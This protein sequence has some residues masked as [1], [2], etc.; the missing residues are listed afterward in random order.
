MAHPLVP[1]AKAA[2]LLRYRTMV[3]HAAEG[4]CVGQGGSIRFAN[5]T[6]LALLGVDAKRIGERPMIEYVH[7]QD[8]AFV[9]SQRDKRSR[10]EVVPPFE[11]RFQRDDGQVSWVEINGVVIDWD[12]APA[13][14]F[15][16]K[17][18]TERHA[19]DEQLK[20]ALAQREAI[21]ETT[22]VGVT[23]LLQRRHQ[24]LNRTFATMLGWDDPAQLLGQETRIHFPSEAEFEQ[25]GAEAYRQID[26]T[27]HHSSVVQL[28][29][30]DGRLIWV[31][32]EG[33]AMPGGASRGT[34]WT[35]VDVTQ[36]RAAE[37]E[38]QNA[39]QREREL[40]EL[41]TR[42]LSM[43]SHEFRTPLAAILSSAEL[44]GHYGDKIGPEEQKS[45]MADLVSAARRMQLMLEDMLTL[46]AAEA[47]RL[48]FAPQPTDLPALCREV[49]AE[50]RSAQASGHVL[51]LEIAPDCEALGAARLVD[52]RLVHHIV[53]NLV[54]NACKYSPAGSE[55]TLRLACGPAE[56]VLEVSDSGIGIPEA[57]LPHL[58]DSF[59]RGGN[60]GNR[61]GSGL[62]L[63]I[64]KRCV[65][66]HG[67]KI[68]VVS[69][70][71]AG[72]RFAVTL[73]A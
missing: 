7:P 61:P 26:L 10:G 32:V 45:I 47:G 13:N 16:L 27:G 70:L 53:G 25:L 15:F 17:D 54:T 28:Q 60:A 24:W 4:V 50:V 59:H 68:A 12:G 56:V 34:V 36:R 6:C 51:K 20:S 11:A 69:K 67:G 58:F 2:E 5:A 65:E 30:K 9:T 66:L 8:R 35:Y 23:F 14:L 63:A 62:G 39:L 48:N 19:L 49:V 72:S 64:V 42:L 57:D 46:G 21:L 3:E 44:I 40:G 55:V 43:A 33:T 29:R 31:Q 1:D 52:G 38:M 41:K 37:E 18:T 22:A 73:P 71:G